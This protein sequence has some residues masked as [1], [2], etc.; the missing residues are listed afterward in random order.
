MPRYIRQTSFRNQSISKHNVH[1]NYYKF[2]IQLNTLCTLTESDKYHMSGFKH[3]PVEQ[4]SMR[5][6][7]PYDMRPSARVIVIR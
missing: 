7:W 5:P 1:I 6:R 3:L 2:I 4:E